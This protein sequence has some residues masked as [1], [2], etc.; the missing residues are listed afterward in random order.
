[1]LHSSVF[2]VVA[3]VSM[4][5]AFCQISAADLTEVI[6]NGEFD[7]EVV[8][9]SFSKFPNGQVPNWTNSSG[10]VELWANSLSGSP[11]L[12][13]DGNSTG[14]HLELSTNGSGEVTTQ[15]VLI[16]NNTSGTAFFSFDGW[17]RS[18]TQQI[19]I[20]LTGNSGQIFSA[21]FIVDT[22]TWTHFD[23]GPIPVSAGENVEVRFTY[24]GADGGPHIDQV[25]FLVETC[26]KFE[27]NNILCDL[28]E[29]GLPTGTNIVTGT[30]T[31]LQDIP[32][33]HLLLPP[34][35]VS[36]AG[37]NV[38]FGSGQ[39]V[40]V[41]DALLNN[42]DSI[43]LGT[44]LS[45]F[46]AIIIKNAMPGDEV[47]FDLILRGAN[48]I[49][50]CQTEICF[51][52]PPCD[53]LQIDRR[54]D[55]IT[56]IVPN[57]DGTVDFCYSFQLTNLLGQDVHHAFLAPNGD[58]TFNPDYFD[59]V[60]ANSNAPLGQG[61]SVTLKTVVS[62]AQPEAPVGFM[63]TIHKEDLSVCCSR[64]Y[65]VLPECMADDP[66]DCVTEPVDKF[67][68][69]IGDVNLDGVVDFADIPAFIALL[70]SGGYQFEADIDQNGVVDF[71]DIPC[72]I[73][74]LIQS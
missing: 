17:A 10:Q 5:L 11:P 72:F 21:S 66:L 48:G 6:A 28:N 2:V 64:K 67:D 1:M 54:M 52:I 59:L 4:T 44:D 8:T 73:E 33:T 24:A 41:L 58:E 42:G 60:A 65:D 15:D 38:C 35:A 51:E 63:I 61:Q 45:N 43:D 34:T 46:D 70:Q 53:C 55:E 12:G 3:S 31:N 22:F 47:C 30:F 7:E 19:N 39:Q 14:Q 16:P 23:S 36:P 56:D 9:G 50:C 32:G 69:S 62:G 25:S 57:D 37:V 68:G 13:T 26:C 29:N 71:A 20:E 74:I 49:E 27:S 18:G 40:H